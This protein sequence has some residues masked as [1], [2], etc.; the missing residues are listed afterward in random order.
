LLRKQL[1]Y[2]F[3][4]TFIAHSAG[5]TVFNAEAV[6]AHPFTAFGAIGKMEMRLKVCLIK[7]GTMFSIPE[8]FSG[9]FVFNNGT[10]A[11][12]KWLDRTAPFLTA[13]VTE[14]TE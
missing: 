11:A 12:G 8:Q 10:F 4:I 6:I 3:T 14:K 9:L 2:A 5:L 13:K 7:G 1:P